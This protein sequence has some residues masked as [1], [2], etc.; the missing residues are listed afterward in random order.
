MSEEACKELRKRF[1][2]S[3]LDLTV[4]TMLAREPTWGYKLMAMV[5]E[6]HDIRVGP[7]VIYPLLDS[8][9]ADGLV[10]C[11]ESYA[12]KR[13]RKVYSVTPEGAEVVRCFGEILL[14]SSRATLNPTD[15]PA[16]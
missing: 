5:K 4:L 3:F 15:L 1:A 11:R 10:E 13:R 12:G 8:L 14:E 2:R 6:V 9:E 7:P 16:V